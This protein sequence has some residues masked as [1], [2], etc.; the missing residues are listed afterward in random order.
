MRPFKACITC[1]QTFSRPPYC[2]IAT[3][4]NRKFCSRKCF[5]GGVQKVCEACHKPFRVLRCHSDRRFC[6][7]KCRAKLVHKPRTIPPQICK[8]C[9]KTFYRKGT[10]DRNKAKYCSQA[11]YKDA[12]KKDNHWNWKGG[13][14]DR[15]HLLRQTPEYKE[16][17][18]AVYKRDNWTCQLCRKKQKHPIAHHIKN[19][20][21][22]VPLRFD[23]KNGVTLCRGCHK[24]VH[25]E[26]GRKT[27]FISKNA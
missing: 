6:S 4:E 3:W 9:K 20:R 21:I 25:S 24:K 14:S 27:Q 17:R 12:N 22:Y 13:I 19:F 1:K 11:C 23:I 16:W 7:V 2:S 5:K 15:D 8:Q 10:R 18:N 26:I